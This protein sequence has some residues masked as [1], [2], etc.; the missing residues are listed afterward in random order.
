MHVVRRIAAAAAA[1]AISQQA[2]A[3]VPL[4]SPADPSRIDQ[5][6]APQR[7][8]A[9]APSL[10]EIRERS[11][12]A[13][14]E[15]LKALRITLRE[16]RFE[17]VTAVP[18]SRLEARAAGYAGREISGEQIFE[19]ARELTALYRSRGYLLSQVIVP[20]QSLAEGRLTLRVVEGYIAEVRVEGDAQLAPVLGAL[21]DKIKAS[22]PL[23]AA[24]LER[25]LLIAND[26]A[27][28]QLRS[29]LTPSQSVGAADLTLIASVKKLEGY[30][31]LDNYGSKY[32]GPG[33]L[34]AALAVNRL[35]GNDQLRVAGVTTGSNDEMNYGQL[36]YGNV[37][38]SEGLRL[39][40]S[41]SV[42]RSRPGDLLKDFEVRGR[43]ETYTVSA[44]Y[45][46][47]RTRNGSV[48]GRAVL[49]YRTNESDTLGVRVIEDRMSA[50][51]L[52]LTWLALDRL[53]GSNALDIELG[54]GL[55][56]TKE[57]DPLKS[58]AGADAE[59]SR[60]LIDYERFQPLGRSFGVTFGLAGQWSDQPLLASEQFALGG[61][62]FGRA[63]EPAEITGD[64]GVALRL[65]PAYLALRYQLYVFYDVGEVRDVDTPPGADAQRS[66]A[67]AGF[68][69]RLN[70]S[71]NFSAALEAAWPLTRPVASYVPYGKGDDVRVLGAL[72]AR[73]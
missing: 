18:L 58:R 14:P 67:S 65:E 40:A 2:L 6:V 38:N 4:P 3:Q 42:A 50:M 39:G 19:L 62:R 28:M 25:Y 8:G 10:P 68:G 17:G 55:G 72:T 30:A 46:L 32:L 43:A 45:P 20:P 69:T 1:S 27:G 59:S 63:Y 21:G 71:R 66:L 48:L 29:V 22:R 23:H 51:R 5:R 12:A 73:F 61:R 15:S 37:V 13:L 26:L 34:T 70:I 11:P 35:L 41:A 24:D 52:G 60:V 9:P 56:G 33:Q 31:S 53:D 44:G 64:R 57:S 54:Q 47:W 16:I 7:R 49:D 36:L